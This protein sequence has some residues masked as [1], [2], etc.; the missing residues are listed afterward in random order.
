MP[1]ATH[2]SALRAWLVCKCVWT[3]A[4]IF[5]SKFKADLDVSADVTYSTFSALKALQN[6]AFCVQ[7]CTCVDFL[8]IFATM[9]LLVVCADANYNTFFALKASL[10]VCRCV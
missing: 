8:P 1:T 5:A 2:F 6:I 10:F 4:T 7:R 3:S 9:A